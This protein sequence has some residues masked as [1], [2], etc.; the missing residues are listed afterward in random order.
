MHSLPSAEAYHDEMELEK[1]IF[2]WVD[3]IKT[4]PS[5]PHMFVKTLS[6]PHL[7]FSSVLRPSNETQYAFKICNTNIVIASSARRGIYHYK[8]F[9]HEIKRKKGFRRA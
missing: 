3:K 1:Q 6:Y 8:L 4:K 2:L 7:V 5:N 9:I